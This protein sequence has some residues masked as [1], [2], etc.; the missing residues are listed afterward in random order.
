MGLAK[1]AQW[2]PVQIQSL[3]NDQLHPIKTAEQKKFEDLLEK[4]YKKLDNSQLSPIQFLHEMNQMK[5]TDDFISEEWSLNFSRIDLQ[6]EE[7]EDEQEGEPS[8]GFEE[9][10]AELSS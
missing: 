8:E 2:L 6:P 4:N 1:E 3:L 5:Y 9:D 10:I 7:E